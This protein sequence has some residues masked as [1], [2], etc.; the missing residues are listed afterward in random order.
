VE[1]ERETISCYNGMSIIT[2]NERNFQPPNEPNPSDQRNPITP[3]ERKPQLV[4]LLKHVLE[5]LS[6]ASLR[7]KHCKRCGLAMVYLKGH[8]W[9][10]GSDEGWEIPLPYCKNCNPEIGNRFHLV[11]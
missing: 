6:A 11:A 1:I 2:P 3:N 10:E 4:D 5:K 8:F 9:L 7:E